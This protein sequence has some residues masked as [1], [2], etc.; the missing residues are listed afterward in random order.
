MQGST[1]VI[2]LNFSVKSPPFSLNQKPLPTIKMKTTVR[3]IITF[4]KSFA[5]ASNFITLACL[6]LISL[7]GKKAIYIIQALFWF[8][9]ISL[10]IIFYYIHNYKKDE[11]YY[12]INLGLSKKR[13]WITT[14]AF[15]F[16]LFLILLILT[17]NAQ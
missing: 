12:Y 6:F 3:L 1:V 13:L 10:G 15:D 7:Y 9:I 16:I 8:K 5:L 17:L 2:L 14:F 4:Y 11:F